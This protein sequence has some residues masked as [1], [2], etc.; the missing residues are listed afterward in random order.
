MAESSFPV[1]DKPLTDQQWGQVI[2]GLGSGILARRSEPYGIPS[3][4][5]DN[6]TNT[7]TIAGRSPVTGDGRAVM[8]GFLHR[9][10]ENEV[11]TCPAVSATTTYYFGLTYDPTRH[12][13]PGGPVSLT[14]TTSRPS[15]SGKV[16]LPIYRITRRAN[17]L[18]SDATVVDERAFVAPQITVKGS[19][20]LP[21]AD[22]VL[23]YTVATDW[24]TGQQ[25]QMQ[26]NGTWKTIGAATALSALSM[27]G[28]TTSGSDIT[29]IRRHDGTSW[30]HI[31]GVI[32]RT[33]SAF[34]QGTDFVTNGT[35]LP[36]S[37]RSSR[38]FI[39]VPAMLSDHAG[40]VALNTSTGQVLTRLA[41]G[42]TTINS[43]FRITF[44]AGWRVA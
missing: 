13:D 9:Y 5:F 16:Y 35:L 11:F 14:L 36:P 43:G 42:T 39:Y 32:T 41:S 34:T 3:G 17:E 21:P 23:S 10:D 19:V 7:F 18:L 2:E 12:A 28:W 33:G 22:S 8:S 31:D 44:Q 38:G 6:A 4:G 20:A 15:G 40:F 26:L 24:E 1:L 30:A 27:T 25:W 37:V 29:V